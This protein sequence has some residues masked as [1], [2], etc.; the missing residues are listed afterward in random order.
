MHRL[1]K[2]NRYALYALPALALFAAVG[3]SKWGVSP[4]GFSTGN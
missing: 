4:Y 2:L 3:H 1:W